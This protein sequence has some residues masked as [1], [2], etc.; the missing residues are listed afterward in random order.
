MWAASIVNPFVIP[1]RHDHVGG[2]AEE[3]YFVRFGNLADLF[4]SLI[5]RTDHLLVCPVGEDDVSI[6]V[7][8][9]DSAL[10]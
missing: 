3:E 6:L 7:A 10:S 4:V 1:M 8:Q 5:G 9:P 2:A